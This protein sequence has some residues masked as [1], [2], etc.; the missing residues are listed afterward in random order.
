MTDW[1]TVPPPKKQSKDE[2]QTV[3]PPP[4]PGG[5]EATMQQHPLQGV[6]KAL[7]NV[8]SGKKEE[9]ALQAILERSGQVGAAAI[10]PR[11][12][13]DQWQTLVH[14]ETPQQ[15]DADISKIGG[16]FAQNPVGRLA[17]QAF[18]DPA[19]YYGGSGSGEKLVDT[20]GPKIMPAI[21]G[22]GKKI[23]ERFPGE[24]ADTMAQIG[25][26]IH[27]FFTPGGKPVAH[28][29]RDL[30]EKHGA[31]GVKKSQRME[32]A[33]AG[34]EAI[35]HTFTA[36]LQD[37]KNKSLRGVN[38]QDET[39]IYKAIHTRKIGSLP[40]E[41]QGKAKALQNIDRSIPWVFGTKAMR[42]RLTDLGFQMP[43]D[44]K[45]FDTGGYGIIHQ[46]MFMED[47]VPLPHDLAP[48]DRYA[49]GKSLGK[50]PGRRALHDTDNPQ[51]QRRKP[52]L[53]AKL[54][55]DP[56][57][58]RAT[59]DRS[60]VNAGKQLTGAHLRTNLGK[61]FGLEDDA[62]NALKTAG[63]R[64]ERAAATSV[65]R[66]A[67]PRSVRQ[68][69][70][71]QPAKEMTGFQKAVKA[72][73]NAGN[74]GKSTLF[75]SP[76]PHVKN[77]GVMDFLANPAVIPKAMYKHA[78]MG[79]G[80]AS[81]GTKARV[82]GDA[83]GEGAAGGKNIEQSGLTNLLDRGGI[84]GKALSHIYKATGKILWSWDDASK[85]A[86]QDFAKHRFPNDPLR[87][88]SLV[89]RLLIDYAH[90]SPAQEMMRLI[91][92]FSTWRTSMPK[93][94][95][96]AVLT[97]PEYAIAADRVTHG[98]AAGAPFTGPDGKQYQSSNPL[99][100]AGEIVPPTTAKYGESALSLTAKLAIDAA[101]A[102][103]QRAYGQ[104]PHV[105][106]S[107]K[108]LIQQTPVLG[109][110]LEYSGHSP[111]GDTAQQGLLYLLSGIHPA[112]APPGKKRRKWKPRFE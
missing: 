101:V 79:F 59:W 39:A 87:A 68:A 86:L 8:K 18:A 17:T 78:R 90:S 47:H 71:A 106:Y 62:A 77:I 25:G 105:P 10:A 4:K 81:P 21:M 49:I 27:N 35:G 56:D 75:L 48:E 80:F 73:E 95:A 91:F 53:D 109:Q 37:L 54:L 7:W 97:H 84:L 76:T 64:G 70:A 46:G 38:P 41:L 6:G 51:F 82:L 5:Y 19:T 34:S 110:A 44:L 43:D 36:V 63:T 99:A 108:S 42:D 61:V 14:G 32:S 89:R 52:D 60:F 69:Y 65:F 13:K 102:A 29:V 20:L 45:M 2:W 40:A 57:A 111:Y 98:A 104:T 16:K 67:V 72:A 107:P 92:P 112:S 100:E 96:E 85:A 58:I 1:V 94:V 88:S 74:I 26:D 93:A 12:L 24:G 28:A 31:E 66:K 11:P 3:A 9:P 83:I 15:Y 103:H 23:A 33:A 50:T 22:L 55:N 30:I